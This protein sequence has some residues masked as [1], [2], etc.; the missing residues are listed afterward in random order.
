MIGSLTGHKP[1]IHDW[2]NNRP[3]QF[4]MEMDTTR[5]FVRKSNGITRNYYNENCYLNIIFKMD[6]E[7]K[8]LRLNENCEKNLNHY[9]THFS[10]SPIAA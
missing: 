5:Y 7:K 9:K 10:V 8:V 3:N 1:D 6:D 2:V 4:Q